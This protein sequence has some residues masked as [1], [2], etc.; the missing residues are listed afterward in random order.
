MK[1]IEALTEQYR[2]V[3]NAYRY[4]IVQHMLPD[5]VKFTKCML[6]ADAEIFTLISKPPYSQ[7][8]ES[9]AQMK[10]LQIPIEVL[11]GEPQHDKQLCKKVLE[12]ANAASEKDGK[13]IIILDLAGEYADIVYEQTFPFLHAVVEDT[14]FGHRKYDNRDYECLIYSVAQSHCKE[15]EA[16]FVGSTIASASEL[17]LRKLGTT[18]FGKH[19]LVIGYGMIGRNTA[20]TL[21]NYG[22]KVIVAE[23]DSVRAVNAFFDGFEIG[24]IHT[25]GKQCKIIIGDTGYR[26]IGLDC[27]DDLG[28]ETCLISGSSKQ[29]EIDVEAFLKEAD[30][31]CTPVAG[32]TELLIRGKRV[33]IANNGNPINYLGGDSIP[34]EIIDFMFAE[35]L[36]AIIESESPAAAQSKR[37]HKVSQAGVA[38]I[39]EIYL[40]N[41]QVGYSRELSKT[42][43]E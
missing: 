41:T 16:R 15:L 21:R 33:Y 8:E 9:M 26:T 40:E 25:H 6:S 28:D 17:L 38:H 2:S 18:L 34:D 37:I 11:S 14:A 10:A 43:H 27:L 12:Q 13:K 29:I 7:S 39:A 1:I 36:Y 3:L 4:V 35:M 24:N 23:K 31:V 42:T 32:L 30:R 5:V 20:L 19:I 22:A